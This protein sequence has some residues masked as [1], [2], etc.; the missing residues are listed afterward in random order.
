[1]LPD[2][3]RDAES[4]QLLGNL[5]FKQRDLEYAWQAYMQALRLDPD[6]PFTC[7]YFANL[8]R[9]CDDKSYARKLYERAVWLAPDIAVVH[10]CI[11]E[12]HRSQGEYALAAKAYERAVAVDP[13]D[14]QAREKL[15]EWRTFM[16]GVGGS[17]I[18][19]PAGAEQVDPADPPAAGR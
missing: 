17:D 16:A 13:G 12:F 14:E 18:V 19:G 6:D 4:Y 3:P 10:W 1:M 9:I 5:Y 2:R 11:A 7:L 15:S 8:L